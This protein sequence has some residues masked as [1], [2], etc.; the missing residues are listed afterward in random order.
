MS[1]TPPT[2]IQR[3]KLVYFVPLENLEATKEAIFA[4]GA[5][6]YPDYSECAWV[7]IGTGQFR[8]IKSAKPHLGNVGELEKVEEARVETVITGEETVRKVVAA[9]KGAHPYEE[10]AYDILRLE[11]F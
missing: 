9:L 8:P 1:A 3:Y 4:A 11:D 10:V 2:N 6:R 7:A 5:G